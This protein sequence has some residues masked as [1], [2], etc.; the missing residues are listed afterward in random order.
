M[1]WILLV[2]SVVLLAGCYTSGKRGTQR[3]LVI[4]DLGLPV[5]RLP[6]AQQRPGILAIEVRAPLWMDSLG[7]NYR[8]TYADASIL[9]E[10]S[11]SRWAG[12]PGQLIEQRLLQQLD[13]VPSGL[14][15]SKCL[16]RIEIAEFS[17][18]FSAPAASVGVLRGRALW[19]DA[20][21][22]A[23]AERPMAIAVPAVSGDARGGVAALQESVGQLATQLLEWEQQLLASG[24]ARVCAD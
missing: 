19:L 16:L 1:R 7:I 13:G 8:L 11:Q 22:R 24:Q 14:V 3:G 17:Q 6:G 12:P 9:R 2:L 10:Y 4:H 21:R 18:V 5:E 15:R 23:L 20:G